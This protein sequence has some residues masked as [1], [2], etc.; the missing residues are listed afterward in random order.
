M[1]LLMGPIRVGPILAGLVA[2]S[3]CTAPSPGR[4][5]TGPGQGRTDQIEVSV[6]NAPL[7]TAPWRRHPF[8]P[9][10]C[11]PRPRPDLLLR[12]P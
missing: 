2:L 3:A 10:P 8:R 6:G 11:A 7:Q 1:S 5:T 12:C 9:H 4:V